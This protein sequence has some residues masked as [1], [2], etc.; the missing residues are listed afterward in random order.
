MIH[1]SCQN[2]WSLAQWLRP[3]YMR[4][5][6][7]LQLLLLQSA[8]RNNALWKILHQAAPWP[9]GSHVHPALTT[10]SAFSGHLVSMWSKFQRVLPLHKTGSTILKSGLQ[11][12]LQSWFNRNDLPC[13]KTWTCSLKQ[14]QLTPFSVLLQVISASSLGQ[15]Y[16]SSKLLRSSESEPP[17]WCVADTSDALEN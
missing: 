4:S 13:S 6:S 12:G 14:S 3:C 11:S 9:K 2:S 1:R 15:R 10:C 16:V 7:L 17:A 8:A 5:A